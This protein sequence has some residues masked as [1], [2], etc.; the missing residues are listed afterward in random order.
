MPLSGLVIE[1]P[2]VKWVISMESERISSA[3]KEYVRFPV[4]AD[5]AGGL[6]NPTSDTVQVALLA[7]PTSLPQV[8]DWHAG[9]WD[10]NVIGGYVAQILVGPGGAVNPGAGTYYAWVQL[11]DGSE[12]VVRQVGQLIID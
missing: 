2:R 9:S 12:V 3:S 6:A 10:Q 4:F 1:P 11:T 5:T 8:S 7:S